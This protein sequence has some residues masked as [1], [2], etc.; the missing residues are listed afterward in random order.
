MGAELLAVA[1]LHFWVVNEPFIGAAG[2]AKQLT[3][4]NVKAVGADA[5]AICPVC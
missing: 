3:L 1:L 2:R 5:V 4:F